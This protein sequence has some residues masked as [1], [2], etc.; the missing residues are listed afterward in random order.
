MKTTEQNGKVLLGAQLIS[1]FQE[2]CGNDKKALE[3]MISE[4]MRALSF[5]RKEF[6][7]Q[8]YALEEEPN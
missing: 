7:W 3:A 8:G 1:V 6:D 2:A 5:I 4:A